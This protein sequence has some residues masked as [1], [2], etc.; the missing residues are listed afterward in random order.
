MDVEGRLQPRHQGGGDRAKDQL[1]RETTADK[2][3]KTFLDTGE[4]E[5]ATAVSER[6]KLYIKNA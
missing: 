3:G 6:L 2:S 5:R 1:T 4:G